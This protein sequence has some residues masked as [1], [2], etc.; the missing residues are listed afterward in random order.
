M[1]RE[2]HIFASESEA[3]FVMKGVGEGYPREF[4]SLFEA[5]RHA[6]TQPGCDGGLVVIYDRD[7]K[8]V[9]RIPFQSRR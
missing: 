3:R 7:D 5:T 2:F 1:R 9:N 4:S 6:R 8:A